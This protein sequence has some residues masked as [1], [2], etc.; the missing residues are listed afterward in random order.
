VVRIQDDLPP[1]VA[2]REFMVIAIRELLD[3]AVKFCSPD[4]PIVVEATQE[5]DALVIR[6]IDE[7]RGI[8]ADEQD[9]IW[10]NFYQ[11]NRE[12]FEDQ[13]AGSGLAIVRGVVEMHGGSARVKSEV[14]VG[15]TFIIRLP[16]TQPETE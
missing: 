9:K 13:G 2:D 3:N 15:S 1:I 16:L 5:D 8:P 11:I 14:E 12:Q 4:Q 7:G 10:E 6:V